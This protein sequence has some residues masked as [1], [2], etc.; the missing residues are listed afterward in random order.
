LFG[1]KEHQSIKMHIKVPA[2]YKT[3]LVKCR[4]VYAE[5]IHKVEYSH[6]KFQSFH[7]LKLVNFNASYSFK[8]ENRIALDKAY[9]RRKKHSDIILVKNSCITDSFYANLA[10]KKADKW[11]T[12]SNCL[13]AGTRRQ[14]LLKQKRIHKKIIPVNT[15]S[16]YS[17]ISLFNAMI[18]FKKIILPCNK[19]FP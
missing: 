12:P 17:H 14:K 19:I 18:P 16:H 4:I 5:Q 10:F 8:F 2:K 13:L 7:S 1:I 11:Y 15:L 6:Y 9:Q 3:G